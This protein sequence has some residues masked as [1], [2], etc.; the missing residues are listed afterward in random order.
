[1]LSSGGP[2]GFVH[3]GVLRALDELGVRPD[4]LV[5]A[6]VGALI[7]TLYCSGVSGGRLTELA[8]GLN[9]LAL[10]AFAIGADERFSGQP[11]ARLVNER[12][13]GRPLQS[14]DPRCAVV[15]LRASDRQPVVFTRGDAGVA[16]QASAAIEGQF[17]PVS[18]RG[19]R[20]VDPD[21]VM[22]LPVRVA[23]ELGAARVL[24]VDASAHEDRAPPGAERYREGDRLKRSVTRPDALAADLN[25]HPYFGYWVSLRREFRERAIAAGYEAAI[26]RRVEITALAR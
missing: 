6:S 14:L 25:L 16:V 20:Y 13:Q 21:K 1:M 12:L 7:A 3:V 26:A 5:G 19:T 11:I 10:A 9:P 24:S 4:L 23:R 22:P 15:A 2:R 8:L 18:I 17:T